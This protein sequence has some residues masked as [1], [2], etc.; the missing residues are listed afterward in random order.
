MNREEKQKAIE[1][2]LLAN[3]SNCDIMEQVN[4]T[5]PTIYRIKARMNSNEDM[6]K[7]PGGGKKPFFNK[8]KLAGL[9]KSIKANPSRSM[10]HHAWRLGVDESIVRR[11]VKKIGGRSLV[12]RHRPYLT[13]TMKEKRV[14][15]CSGILNLLKRRSTILV[16]SDEKLLCRPCFKQAKRPVCVC[17]LYTSPSPRDRG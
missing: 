11:A 9:K 10:R 3:V 14:S 5:K 13:Q 2:L 15:R 6:K 4:T 8:K 7:A 12:R 1:V 16:F 17:L